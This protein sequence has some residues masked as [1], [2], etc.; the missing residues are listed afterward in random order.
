MARYR[1]PYVMLGAGKLTASLWKS[2]GDVS[3]CAYQFNIFRLC[4][5]SGRVTQCLTPSDVP[6]LVKLARVLAQVIVDDGCVSSE[7]RLD[8][9]NLAVS[10][11]SMLKGEE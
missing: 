2:I 10:I 1:K 4:P 11:D 5:D 6:D 9:K 8:L 3:G 7:L